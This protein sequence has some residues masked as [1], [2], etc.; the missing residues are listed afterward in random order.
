MIDKLY[1]VICDRRDHPQADSYVASLIAKGP[2]AIL[3][4]IGEET[5]EVIIAAKNRGTVKDAETNPAAA[6]TALVHEIA[7]LTFHTLILMADQRI[8]PGAVTAELKRRFGT[9][10]LTEKANRK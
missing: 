3:K 6:T 7:D 5:A 9:S 2:D 4:K 8:P 10:G 1:Q